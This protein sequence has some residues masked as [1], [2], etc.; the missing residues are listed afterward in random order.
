MLIKFT[1]VGKENVQIARAVTESYINVYLD[2]T[3]EF[4]NESKTIV[5]ELI[6][7]AVIHAE[8]TFIELI[9]LHNRDRLFITIDI[10]YQ[11]MEK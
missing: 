11:L 10:F 7:N 8:P 2:A 5:S 9:L 6:T 4:I 3:Q 1:N